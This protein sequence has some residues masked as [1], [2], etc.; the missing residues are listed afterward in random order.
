LLKEVSVGSTKRS[1]PIGRIT[2]APGFIKNAYADTAGCHSACDSRRRKDRI[3]M[4]G[5]TESEPR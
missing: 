4:Q 3:S 1:I 2:N 5:S